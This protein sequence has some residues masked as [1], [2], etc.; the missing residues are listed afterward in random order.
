MTDT[1][2]HRPAGTTTTGWVGWVYFAGIIMLMVGF[3][4][5]LAGLVALFNDTFF[6][7]TEGGLIL[8]VDYTV[9]GLVHLLIGLTIL[10]AGWAVLNGRTWGRS[11]GIIL[12]VLSS[13]ANMMFIGAYPLWSIIIIVLDVIVIYAL[14]VHGREAKN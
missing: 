5:G 2:S 9:W 4:Q 6:L 13:I 11:I 7:V 1:K 14:A 12:S 3:F 10:A 8:K